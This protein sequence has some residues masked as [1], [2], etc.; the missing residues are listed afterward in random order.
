MTSRGALFLGNSDSGDNSLD[1]ITEADTQHGLP[2]IGKD[3]NDS[4][5]GVF[6]KNVTAIGEQVVLGGRADGFHQALA[7]FALQKTDDTTNFLEG[8]TALTQLADHCDFGEI[9][10][11]IKAAM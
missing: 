10:D 4:A 6:Q 11:G 3:V 7:E 1:G 5:G 2:G 9:V 8:K